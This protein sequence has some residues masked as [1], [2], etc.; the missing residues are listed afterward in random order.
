MN[1]RRFLLPTLFAAALSFSFSACE[2]KP[3]DTPKPPQAEQAAAPGQ[4]TAPGPTTTGT[5]SAAPA[6]GQPAPAAASPAVD[7]AKISGT[8]GF[9]GR[10]PK[11]V[12]GFATSLR[13]HE[14]WTGLANSK[15]AAT[16]L[17]F[18]PIKTNP[19]FVKLQDQWKSEQG[20][21]ARDLLQA[22]FGHEF[23]IAMPAGFTAKLG[24]WVELLS[25]YQQTMLQ[26]YFMMG[27]SGG[28]PDPSK[29]QQILKDAAPQFVPI[30]ARCEVPPVFFA[31]KAAQAR[32]TIDAMLKQ[33]TKMV[34]S[35]LPP[36]FEAGQFKLSDKYDFQSVS[37]NAK[38]LVAQ[39]QE[40]QL[41]MQL[42]EILGDEA[43]AKE[44]LN[45]IVAKRVEVA[46]G[47]VDDYLV[48]ALGSDHAHVKLA[49]SDAESALAIGDVGKR[50]AQFVAQRPHGLS[51]LSKGTFEALQGKVA[52]ADQFKSFAEELQGILKPEQIEA[53]VADAR[54][55]E[56]KAQTLYTN[57]Y[58]PAV[59]VD[60]WEGGFRSEV[61]G[62]ARNK[63]IDSSKPLSFG[64]LASA[65]SLLFIDGRSNAAY[66]KATADFLEDVAATLWS[67]YE[68][69]GRT[70]IPESERQGA[71]MIEATA[72]PMLVDLWRSTRKLG[73]GLGD[74]SALVIDLAGPMPKIPDVPPFLAEG[75]VPRVAWISELKDRASISEAWKGYY[76]IIK[77]LAA[78]ADQ[79]Q[80][81]P[82]PQMR[83]EGSAEIH[84]V[85]LPMP[86]DDFLPHV[87]ITADRWMLSSAPSF[88][89][90]LIG[91][92]TA[93]S[94]QPM[95]NHGNMSFTALWDYADGWVKVVD[96]HSAEFFSGND[97]KFREARPM[98][99][100]GLK[101][102]RS[103][104]AFEWH[105]H[106]ETGL[107][108]N[109]FR[110]K[111]K[112]LE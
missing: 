49:A 46:W 70:M 16:L 78:L 90:E 48:V 73:Q 25:S 66:T 96:K 45:A 72:K 89:K 82:E 65:A 71:V 8:Y 50:A 93:P 3:T 26:A 51:Y 15:W 54:R 74:E 6:A 13:F 4:T 61:F 81:I 92:S 109:S 68:K 103:L 77:Q 99:D 38:K 53:M 19:E 87:A 104:Q 27:M 7:V 37:V 58:D 40:V 5:K 111:L 28:A 62:G 34:G 22:F 80:A 1:R 86:T 29:M 2:K 102:A 75:K 43:K 88:T 69:Y 83:Q 12:E 41:E 94:G 36:A 44:A 24:P 110:L 112:D 56:A 31:F 67:W 79:S 11:D 98:I 64:G 97:A 101:L 95:G 14:L 33:F 32:P 76:S 52:F 17:D 85:P 21:Q 59:Q 106:E 57:T 39:F 105:F 20:Q 63:A 42:K 47:W 9:V 30:L 55:L 18:P 107:S 84:F 108:R 35:E 91:K 100:T 23:T 10:L 60:M